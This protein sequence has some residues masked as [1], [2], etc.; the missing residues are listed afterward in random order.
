MADTVPFDGVKTRESSLRV[1]LESR[2]SRR[3]TPSAT[4]VRSEAFS[5]TVHNNVLGEL[6]TTSWQIEDVWDPPGLQLD[7]DGDMDEKTGHS[8]YEAAVHGDASAVAKA[9][10]VPEPAEEAEEDSS[11]EKK[12]RGPWHVVDAFGVEP[13]AHAAG[14][15]Y[16]PVCKLLL[17][18]QADPHAKSIKDETNA[19][20]RAA[21]SG[22]AA[23]IEV[24]LEHR[25]NVDEPSSERMSSLHLAAGGAH[26]EAV[27]ALLAASPALEA[28]DVTGATPLMMAAQGG[29]VEAVEAILDAGGRMDAI[30]E[31]GWNA[32]H[33][34]CSFGHGQVASLLAK[35]GAS[36]NVLTRGGRSLSDMNATIAAQLTAE[37]L[38][39]KQRDAAE[40]E[41]PETGA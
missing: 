30:D 37:E 25:A 29:S 16:T 14:Y 20:H 18:S 3:P 2:E 21:K 17:E 35:R 23:V 40:A 26:A 13:L 34:A 8:V 9:L 5:Y 38:E 41:Q 39:R 24:L 32:L 15:G 1:K 10:G 22:H 31:N 36:L 11:V 33:F 4:S 6:P 27:R 12:E 28:Y 7:V 19:L